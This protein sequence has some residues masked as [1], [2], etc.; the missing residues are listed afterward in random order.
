MFLE[1]VTALYVPGA[2]DVEAKQLDL[3]QLGST[4]LGYV[5]ETTSSYDALY[6]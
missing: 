1:S 6:I 2:T 5:E 3:N 4:Q